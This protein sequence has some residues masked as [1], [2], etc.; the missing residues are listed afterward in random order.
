M[1]SAAEIDPKRRFATVIYRIA[2]GSF[3]HLLG[4]EV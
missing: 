3:D 2:K 4:D 1:V